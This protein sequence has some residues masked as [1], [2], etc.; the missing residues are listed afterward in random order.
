MANIKRSYTPD[1]RADA[2]RLVL[3]QGRSGLGADCPGDRPRRS[4]APPVLAAD[5]GDSVTLLRPK[6]V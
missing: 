3:E 4:Q 1:F 2:V 5:G 6:F